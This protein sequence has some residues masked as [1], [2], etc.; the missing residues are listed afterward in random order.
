LI[1]QSN[2]SQINRS[3]INRSQSNGS[4]SITNQSIVNQS[5]AKQ[6]FEKIKINQSINLNLLINLFKISIYS[7]VFDHI[8]SKDFSENKSH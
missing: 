6:S 3:Q 4:Q 8:E 5:I 1:N 7:K 2:R